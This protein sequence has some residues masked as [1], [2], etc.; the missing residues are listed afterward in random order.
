MRNF[1]TTR[2]KLWDR[3]A[4][5]YTTVDAERHTLTVA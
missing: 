1:A 2:L 3:L 5:W 4:H